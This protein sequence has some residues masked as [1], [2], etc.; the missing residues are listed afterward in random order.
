M[1]IPSIERLE[2]VY[3]ES[4]KSGERVN[5]HN[6]LLVIAFTRNMN[7]TAVIWVSSTDCI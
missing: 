6:N 1:N 3:G 7:N 5:I 4:V 2:K